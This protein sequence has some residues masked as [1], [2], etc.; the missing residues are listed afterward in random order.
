M[1]NTTWDIIFFKS[2]Y[3]LPELLVFPSKHNTNCQSN[4]NHTMDPKIGK[5]LLQII[6]TAITKKVITLYTLRPLYTRQYQD[7]NL[8][9]ITY[10]FNAKLLTS[11]KRLN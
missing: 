3:L 8:L 11:Q 9:N 5:K 2:R 7:I 10:K 4:Y 6:T 1:Y